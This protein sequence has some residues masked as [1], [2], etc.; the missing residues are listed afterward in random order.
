MFKTLFPPTPAIQLILFCCVN[1]L[2]TFVLPYLATELSTNCLQM[3]KL[4]LIPFLLFI[5]IANCQLLTWTPA[6]IK[7]SSNPVSITMN[8]N[9]GNKALLNYTPATGVYVH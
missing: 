2:H 4:L 7:E 3:K 9:F 8:A 1:F 5:V 6:F